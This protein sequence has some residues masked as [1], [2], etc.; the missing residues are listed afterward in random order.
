MVLSD[1]I[2][3]FNGYKYDDGFIVIIKTLD[4]NS[5]AIL[6]HL[7][8]AIQEIRNDEGDIVSLTDLT[9]GTKVEILFE[10]YNLTKYGIYYDQK[11]FL[12]KNKLELNN[13]EYFILKENIL[14]SDS[15]DFNIAYQGV[16]DLIKCLKEIS[17]FEVTDSIILFQEKKGTSF[18]LDYKARDLKGISNEVTLLDRFIKEIEDRNTEKFLLYVNELIDFLSEVKEKNRFSYLIKN[19]KRFYEKCE[20]SYSYYLTNFSYNKLKIEVD[21]TAIDFSK[22]IRS[23]INDSQTK[24]IAIPAASLLIYTSIDWADSWRLKSL[25]LVISSL[26][27]SF[28]IEIF[29]RNQE[30]SLSIISDNMKNYKSMFRLKNQAS[31]IKLDTLVQNSFS[32]VDREIKSQKLNLEIIRWINWVIPISLMIIIL[33][34]NIDKIK[35]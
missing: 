18:G 22:N 27:F 2:S 19:F 13:S 30:S 29:I 17:S 12:S 9:E 20:V 34:Q 25:F 6:N 23:V 26:L 10:S 16:V 8:E 32:K 35:C 1:L 24:L 5:I 31:D 14:F 4:A 33:I 11:I 3:F 28:L 15:N 21:N 7:E